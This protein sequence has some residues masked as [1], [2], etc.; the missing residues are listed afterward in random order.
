MNSSQAVKETANLRRFGAFQGIPRN[1]WYVA[2]GREEIGSEPLGRKLLGKPVVLY[3][4]TDGSVVAMHDA[5]PHR[6]F[7]L[8]KS[9]VVGDDIQCRYHGNVFNELGTCI[10]MPANPQANISNNMC[11]TTYPVVESWHWVWIWMGDPALADAGLIPHFDCENNPAYEHRFYSPLGPI[12]CNFQIIHDNLAD[13]TH[14]SFLHEGLL[15]DA[16]NAEMALAEPILEQLGEATL[17]I[18]RLMPDFVP[19]E[20]VARLY[21]LQAGERYSRR[22]EVWHHLPGLL[23]AFNRYYEYSGESAQAEAGKLAAEH[24][25]TVGITPASENTS[26]HLTAVSSSFAQTEADKDGLLYVIGQ[27]IEAFTAV[28]SYFENYTDEAVEVS[29]SSDK[30]GLLTRKI[31]AAMVQ[32]EQAG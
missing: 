28:Q 2:A 11:V 4:K 30:L 29:M 12:D 19:N 15:D 7:P 10:E 5:C 14:T 25:T 24:I 31:I 16:D 32:K 1:A 26:Y 6:G 17:R 18:T 23:T 20:D 21:H 9:K 27:D 8:S 22:L 13:A 3:R